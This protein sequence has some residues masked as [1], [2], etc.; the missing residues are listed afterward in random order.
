MKT[1]HQL[2]LAAS[3]VISAFLISTSVLAA[4][5]ESPVAEIER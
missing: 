5:S 2:S 4:E 1:Q 3:F